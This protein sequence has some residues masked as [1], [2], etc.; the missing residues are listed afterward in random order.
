M[1]EKDIHSLIFRT[2][3]QGENVV[4]G[5]G[6]DCAALDFGGARLFL[7]AADQLVSG[8][9]YDAGKTS[10]SAAAAKLL[11]RN[12]S[13]IAAMGGEPAYALLTIASG[14]ADRRWMA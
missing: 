3:R 6:D 12:L 5:P 4:V 14:S 11:N 1:K 7:M 2:F 8:V 10:A 9:H 13:D